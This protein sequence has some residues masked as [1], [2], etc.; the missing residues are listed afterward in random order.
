MTQLLLD[1]ALDLTRQSGA[2]SLHLLFPDPA[3]LPLFSAAGMSLRKDCQFH[4]RN[5]DYS[6]FE[7]F[8]GGFT[9]EKRKKAKRERRRV[10][11]EAAAGLNHW[12]GSRPLRPDQRHAAA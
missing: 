5:Q 3:E 11:E 7:D 9:A 4:W 2:S 6:C 8:L 1:T 10:A 12:I